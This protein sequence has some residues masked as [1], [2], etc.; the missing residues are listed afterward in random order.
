MT[1]KLTKRQ[2]KLER[3]DFEDLV[4]LANGRRMPLYSPEEQ[5]EQDAWKVLRIIQRREDLAAR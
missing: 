1:K 5:R 3:S 2:E 4:R